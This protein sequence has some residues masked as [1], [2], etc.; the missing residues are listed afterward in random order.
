MNKNGMRLVSLLC[1][2][3]ML[4]GVLCVPAETRADADVLYGYTIDRLSTRSG[5]GTNYAETGTFNH[6]KNV[7]VQVRSRAWDSS[8]QI[9]WV[10][11]LVG[12]QWLWT[13]YKRFDSATLPL[14]VIPLWSGTP[15]GGTTNPPVT[16]APTPT[17]QPEEV[18]LSAYAIKRISTRTGPS[19]SY[20]S[21]GNYSELANTW[22]SVRSRGWDGT[23][24]M[25]WIEVLVNGKWLWTP[26]DRFDSNTLNIYDLPIHGIAVQPDLS[27]VLWGYSVQRISCRKGPGSNY[28]GGGTYN[29]LKNQWLP[30]RSRAWDDGNDMWWVEVLIGAEWLWTNYSRFDSTTLPLDSIPL[31][32]SMPTV[33]PVVTVTRAPTPVPTPVPTPIPTAVPTAVPTVAPTEMTWIEYSGPVFGQTVYGY[34]LQRLSTRSGPG[35]WYDDTGSYNQLANVW[36]EV[37]SRAWDSYNGIWWVEVHV[38]NKWLWTGYNRFDS[39][40][41]PLNGIPLNPYY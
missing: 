12:D 31:F 38:G 24:E 11:V 36:V 18:I 8:N 25:W 28:G 33:P 20:S 15:S 5:P 23:N 3:V 2:L 32:N 10:E 16:Q 7:W 34:T 41:L 27:G 14:E 13:G 6:L 30:I 1:L 40:T 4:A 9:W 29:A 37:R 39:N 26:Y 21:G 19:S 22:L 35:T 17:P